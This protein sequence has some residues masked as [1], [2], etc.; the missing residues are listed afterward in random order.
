MRED[1]NDVIQTFYSMFGQFGM[2]KALDGFGT[3]YTSI[4]RVG[5]RRRE[6]VLNRMKSAINSRMSLDN[7]RKVMTE[8]KERLERAWIDAR[9]RE[10]PI[11]RMK[12]DHLHNTIL[13][14]DRRIDRGEWCIGQNEDL[15]ELLTEMEAERERRKLPMPLI[16]IKSLAYR[17]GEI[18]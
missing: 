5:G 11:S 1:E 18:K 3:N 12:D 13:L 7:H 6:V 17:K 9:G 8:D 16:P 2:K 14:I 15:M 10:H 4:D